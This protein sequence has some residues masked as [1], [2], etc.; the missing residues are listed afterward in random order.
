[1]RSNRPGRVSAG[2]SDSGMFVA[3]RTMMPSFCS[4]PSISVNNWFSV[5]RCWFSMDLRDVPMES[6]S[7]MK[8]MHGVFFFAAAKSWRTRLDPTPTNI[9]SNSLPLR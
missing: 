8:T 4:N 7:S 2:S 5:F 1:M 3:A 9:S 6:I